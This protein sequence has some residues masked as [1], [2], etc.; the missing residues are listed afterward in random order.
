MTASPM[1]FV[2][3]PTLGSTAPIKGAVALCNGLVRHCEVTLVA[4]KPGPEDRSGL[5]ARVQV[6]SLA[7]VGGW[8]RRVRQYRQWLRERGGRERVTSISC[9]LSADALNGFARGDAFTIATVRGHLAKAYRFD[10]GRWGT[11]VAWLHHRLLG[12]LDRVVALSQAMESDLRQR[13]LERV[14]VI[15]NFVDEPSLDKVRLPLHPPNDRTRFVFL[16]RLTEGKR[17][18]L[19]VEAVRRVADRGHDCELDIIGD[20]PMRAGVESRVESLGL[21][22]RVTLHGHLAQPLGL[23]QL[24]DCLVLPSETEGVSR[25]VLEA[26]YLGVPC[27]VRDVDGNREVVEPGRNGE[28][29]TRD[30]DLADVMEQV[31]RHGVPPRPGKPGALLPGAFRRAPN[32]ARFLALVQR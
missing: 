15:G 27:I 9:C 30:E 28:V 22:D 12:R 10:Y 18:D 25:T 23:M 1:V 3:V 21:R 8:W 13:G 11:A 26:L 32:V 4:L 17:P 29:F 31:V 20:G 24:A 7:D 14:E 19:A 2:L 16:G 5:D 6:R